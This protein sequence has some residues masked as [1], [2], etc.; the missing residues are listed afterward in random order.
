MITFYNF[1]SHFFSYMHRPIECFCHV[2]S[3]KH[4]LYRIVLGNTTITFVFQF[5]QKSIHHIKLVG[6]H[7][8]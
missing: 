5:I 2:R 8:F 1:V 3:E 7:I 4:L 6:I